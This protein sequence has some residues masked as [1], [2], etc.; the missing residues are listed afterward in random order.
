MYNRRYIPHN[1]KNRECAVKMFRNGTSTEFVC[2]KYHCSRTSLWR[3]NKKYDNTLESLKDKSHKPIKLHPTAH[4]QEEIKHIKNYLRR[5]PHITLIELWYKL[6]REKGYTRHPASLYR[7]LVKI[8]KY[9]KIKHTEYKKYVPKK[10]DTPKFMGEKWQVDVKYVPN[11]CKCDNLPHDMRFYQ[12]TCIDEATRERYI[13]PYR[14]ISEQNT[15]D[16]I[17][18]C[19]RYFK[20]I[21]KIIQ[22]D[23]G[24]E[25]TYNKENI[26]KEHPLDTFCKQNSITH[27]L[28]K[29][30]TPRHNGKVERSHRND[31]NRFYAF[32]KFYS[33]DDLKKQMHA[34]L[35]RSNNIPMGV[36]NYLT[37][38]EQ[39]KK[40]EQQNMYYLVA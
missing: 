30:R 26:K 24:I 32:L 3:W 15:V 39:R 23:N 14:E 28:I 6:K 27:K 7:F 21:P 38:K 19:I 11:E 4:T 37:P 17:K 40:L 18:R 22:T 9:E 34:Y 25:F 31:N 13:F 2:S 5:N 29:P 10:Y 35:V 8:G 33:F 16:F 1:V 12:Y 20:Y 36:L